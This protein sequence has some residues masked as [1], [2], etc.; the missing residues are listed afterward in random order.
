MVEVTSR[1]NLRDGSWGE[2]KVPNEDRRFLNGKKGS[3]GEE[4]VPGFLCGFPPLGSPK[5][6]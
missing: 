3:W 2:E 1:R 6:F 5:S 4:K